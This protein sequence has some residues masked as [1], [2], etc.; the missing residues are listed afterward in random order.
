MSVKLYI[1]ERFRD[2]PLIHLIGL[3]KDIPETGST[4]FTSA[5]PKDFAYTSFSFVASPEEADLILLPSGIRSLDADTRAYLASARSLS[6]RIGK[7]VIAFPAGDL[8]HRITI[9]DMILIR[10]SQYGHRMG[11]NEIVVPPFSEDLGAFYGVTI[12]DKSR[13]PLVGF[14]GWAGFPTLKSRVRYLLDTAFYSLVSYLPG[15]AH[16][17]VYKKGVYWRRRSMGL[18]QR[19]SRIDT[20]FIMR[21]SF[22]GSVKTISLP[23]EEARR[24]YVENM[25]SVDFA[26]TPKGDAN[27]SIRLY[28]ALSTGRVPIIIDT[29]M[30]LPFEDVLDYSS[31]SLR[32]PHTKI[33]RLAD[34]VCDF[35]ASLSNEQFKDM[36]KKAR[37]AYVGYLRYDAVFN[38]IF[39]SDIIVRAGEEAMK[40]R[41]RGVVEEQSLW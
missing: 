23:P 39:G 14:C 22:S 35:H 28:E 18:L 40:N 26:L 30:P 36:Q 9:S 1:F 41:E 24:E 7:P 20:K 32:V 38:Q 19:D 25:R 2:E 6:V 33:G 29:D 16:F 3:Y 17:A 8:A 31:F 12:R 13:R 15:L 11:G 27:A 21:K 4:L 37:E 10:G 34:Y 5:R